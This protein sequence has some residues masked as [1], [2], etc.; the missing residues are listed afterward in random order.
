[1]ASW[2]GKSCMQ[3]GMAHLARNSRTRKLLADAPIAAAA[4]SAS[5]LRTYLL[6]HEYVSM[7][8]L[9]EAGIKVPKFR[10]ASTPA[11]VKEAASSG[12]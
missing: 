10:V 2:I 1:M 3:L 12:G 5:Q 11:E 8:V 6:L 9:Q 4:L 7:G